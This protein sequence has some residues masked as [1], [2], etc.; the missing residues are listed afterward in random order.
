LGWIP[1]S[2][3]TEENTDPKNEKN[4]EHPQKQLYTIE[5]MHEIVNYLYKKT[6]IVY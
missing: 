6:N 3:D 4:P 2:N 5:Q 1:P